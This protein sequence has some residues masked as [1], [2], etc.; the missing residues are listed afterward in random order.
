MQ[1]QCSL[2]YLTATF[3][4][5][6]FFDIENDFK[7]SV[8]VNFSLPFFE[9][10]VDTQSEEFLKNRIEAKKRLVGLLEISPKVDFD[11][12]DI[13]LYEKK[14]ILEFPLEPL[15]E[16]TFSLK[17]FDSG[18][19][20]EKVRSEKFVLKTPENKFFGFR[21]LKK[22]TLFQDTASP[23]LELL[24]YDS[25]K[26]KTKFKICRIDNETYA[27]IE[28]FQ[29]QKGLAEAKKKFFTSGIDSLKTFDCKE[30][31]VSFTTEKSGTKLQKTTFDFTEEIGNPARSGLYYVTFSDPEDRVFNERVQPPVFFG[32][33]DSHITMK[34]SRNGEAF[35]FVN[36]FSGKPLANQNIRVYANEFVAKDTQWNR[37]KGEYD[38]TYFSPLEKNVFGTSILL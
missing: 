13:V 37:E 9:D 10:I 32:I 28:V 6:S 2:K 4:T 29:S 15:K 38:V 8:H 19:E 16:Y 12:E 20:G 33:I 5:G 17:S 18:I 30:K 26:T 22:M 24:S 11:E 14:A 7:S 35:F 27:K 25:G 23:K 3:S 21:I 36:D 1:K 31:E 34:I